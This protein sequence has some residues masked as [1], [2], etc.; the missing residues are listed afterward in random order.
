MGL[1]AEQRAFAVDVAHLILWGGTRGYEFSL[2]EAYR[3][4]E[5]AELY[6][7]EGR[8]LAHS[9][10]MIRLAIDLDLFIGGEYQT[11]SEVYRPL[12]DFWKS[13]S[14]ENAWGGDFTKP[15]GNHFS[16]SY[17]GLR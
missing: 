7:K 9:L 5:T 1:S 11:V 15:D 17:E 4:P 3:P 16:R 12:G 10:H 8:G 6:A 14:P 2:G 13:L